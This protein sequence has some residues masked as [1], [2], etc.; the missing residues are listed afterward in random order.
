MKKY[1]LISF[2]IL[3]LTFNSQAINQISQIKTNFECPGNDYKPWVY[4]YV[5]DGYL[6]KEGITADLEAMAKVGI[7]G[8]ILMEVNLGEKP[9]KT[10]FMSPEWRDCFQ[11]VLN[12]AERLKLQM[13]LGSG[14]GWAGSG[15][16]WIKADQS[17]LQL[18]SSKI[19]VKGKV[20]VLLPKPTPEVPYFGMESLNEEMKKERAD[21]YQDVC[22]LAFPKM[23]SIPQIS[24]IKE[25]ALYIR[26]PY[27]ST[28]GSK[29]LLKFS[30][31]D[32]ESKTT[33]LQM[34]QMIDVSK[35]MQPDGR[36]VWT[37]PAGEW[38]IF[39]FGTAT[40]A[41]NTRPAPIPGYGF[42]CSKLDTSA[43]NYH[44]DNYINKLIKDS[45]TKISDT[46]RSVGWN[47]LHIDSWE[48]GSQNWSHN[49][50]A[51]FKKRRGYDI[52][53][54]LPVYSGFVVS[55]KKI[56][57]RFL[58]DM[59]ITAQ[60]LLLENHAIHLRKIAHEHGFGLSIE[61]YDMNPTSDLALGAIA[62]VPQCEFWAEKQGF[63]T[64]FSCFEATSIAHTCNKNIVAAEAF[65]TN[66]GNTPW[67]RTP[68]NLKDQVDWVFA[69]G[70]NR[71][72]VH[73]YAFQPWKDKFP[74]MT[75]G[76]YGIQYERTQTWW[77]FTIEWH[78]YIT[79][80]Q[81]LLRQGKPVA[82]ILFLNPEGAPT[83]F[84]P[85]VSACTGNSW[86]PDKK[87][88]SFDGC[89]PINL[90]ENADVKNGKIIFPG[91]IEY[92]I[93]VLPTTEYMTPNLLQKINTLIE[94]G[95]TV[96]GFAPKYS[97]SLTDYPHCDEEVWNLAQKMWGNDP[98]PKKIGKGMLYPCTA[99]D[100]LNLLPNFQSDGKNLFK[101]F[102]PPFVK[103][104]SIEAV[105]KKLNIK[106]DFK[107]D[108]AFRYI[109]R[110]LEKGDIYFVSNTKNTSE[111]GICTFRT[112]GNVS[113]L[114]PIDGKEYQAEVLTQTG[115]TTTV[116]IPLEGNGSVFVLFKKGISLFPKRLPV[117]PFHMK[118]ILKVN[119]KWTVSFDKKWG[120]PEEVVFDSLKDWSL[121]DNLG[122]KYYSGTAKYKT[123]IKLNS[124][125]IQGRTFIDLGNVQVMARVK[126]NGKEL[127]VAW[128]SPYRVE[129]TGCWN[130]GDNTVEIEVVNLWINR[131]IG[132]Q[133]L[134]E[135][136]RFT[137]STWMP[138]K[139]TDKL[140]RSGLLGPVTIQV[141]D[142]KPYVSK[143]I[144]SVDKTFIV[145]PDTVTLSVGCS[146]E[147]AE[148][149]YTLNGTT[150][151]ENSPIYN[152][153]LKI[154]DYANIA[155][156]AFKNNFE[157]SDE[158]NV[159]IDGY[160]PK[161]N[162]LNYEY[163]EGEWTKIP[164]FDKMTPLK[165]GTTITLDPSKL[166]NRED[167]FGLKFYGSI[168]LATSGDYTFYLLS[169]D[170]SKLYIDGKPIV[171]N[172]GCHGDLEKSGNTQL[173]KGKHEIRIDY[174][175]NINGESLQLFY[176][177]TGSKE[178]IP[179]RLMKY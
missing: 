57:E 16:P 134:P 35:F 118:S 58:W 36:L 82:D 101:G 145:K 163:F 62:D 67:S 105:L 135:D 6:N 89:D 19:N 94:K 146:T 12:E 14:P 72:I 42:E 31:I 68:A 76:Q 175:D 115:E 139:K 131:L 128:C 147:N 83:V 124:Q 38:T 159:L 3:I 106:E 75:M 61:P 69:A 171:D 53:P 39:R 33:G 10:K 18:I 77:N 141:I 179:L 111:N 7:G 127:G 17:M 56:S 108:N 142:D 125:Q 22:V 88:Y 63:N 138:F 66:W 155:V 112:K 81:Y 158:A 154:N 78:D 84:E 162:G 103:Y 40:T 166:K 1:F 27:S 126:I 149:H 37:A 176:S 25:K 26:K 11:H 91:G 20:D 80:C 45:G 123:T 5:M 121:S 144:I 48:M 73:R 74:G 153:P 60:D 178:E 161:V 165:K 136:K 96:M 102:I 117:L 148:I 79:R 2:F 13:A 119:S 177:L 152:T 30:T 174:F 114:N 43:L 130:E 32:N 15:G 90:I 4:W 71:I 116:K 97:P 34:K 28:N 93:L 156:K 65:T 150:P 129:T 21:Y 140:V 46:R 110:K 169:D 24:D 70:I 54:F 157:S 122:I 137:W 167:H 173:A 44:L 104:S 52:E 170:G 168:S 49:F 8:F 50:A 143:P 95:A 132:D 29:P 100:T 64:T 87:G 47:M 41:A 86:M 164:D 113:F 23:D 85:P 9:G 172:D 92:R 51:E 151:T 160:D 59:R 55:N 133:T 109:H 107:C 98:L 120:G 99:I